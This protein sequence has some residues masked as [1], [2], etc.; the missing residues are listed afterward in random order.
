[1]AASGSIKRNLRTGT[2]LWLR[3]GAPRIGHLPLAH[4]LRVDVAIVGAGISGALIADAMLGA[5]QSVAVFDRRGPVMGSTPA[6]TALLQFE[7][8]TPLTILTR[9]I[10][11]DR[12]VRAWLRSA[13]AVDALRGRIADLGLRCAFHERSTAYLPGNTLDLA[14]LRREVEARERVGLRSAFIGPELLRERTG[15][16]G[17]GAIWS[18]GAGELDPLALTTGLWRSALARGAAI[19]APV[20]IVD[21]EPGRVATALTTRTGHVVRAR[22]VV[23][24]T[25]YELM[26]LIKPRGYAVHSTWA[27]ATAPQPDRLW[28]SKALIWESADP[29]LYLRTTPD[30]RLIAG[31][32]DEDFSTAEKRDALLPR[33]I[34]AIRRKVEKLLPGIDTTP[35]FSWAGCFGGSD[36]GLP[37][38]GA[39][40]GARRCYAVL[41][42]GGN[43]I[44]FSMIAAQLLQREILGIADPD[45]ALF[46][47]EK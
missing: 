47:L 16:E 35:E 45:A 24:A 9:K 17:R 4:N 33:K 37:A 40:P 34:A 43:G 14:G 19:H 23:F 20:E 5:G 10:G 11:R 7:I 22:H 12:A 15:I 44:T 42:Y 6:S 31:G 3:R 27:F 28:P 29:Y 26:K 41:G 32:E 1:M 36:T 2:P 39:I 25:G 21:V 8:D 18:N 38:I 46:A 13:T 30:G